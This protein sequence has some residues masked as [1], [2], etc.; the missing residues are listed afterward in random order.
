MTNKVTEL[1]S[2]EQFI[3]DYTPTYQP[4]YPLLMK[5]AVSYS[6]EVGEVKFKRL[7]VVGDIRQKR[8]TPKQNVMHQFGAKMGTKQFAKY[9]FGNQF[10]QSLFQSQDGIED[11]VRQALDEHQKQADELA[12]YGEGTS[13]GTVVNNGLFYSGDANHVTNSSVELDTDADTLID[14][15]TQ[16]MSIKSDADD[17]A[18][19]KLMLFY[20]ANLRSLYD[21]N[22]S[23]DPIPFKRVLSEAC[24]PNYSFAKIPT[25]VQPAS[26]DGVIIVNLDQIKTHYMTL[27]VLKKQG[28]ND[29]KDY[30]WFNFLMGSMMVEVL[31]NGAVIRQPF[32][33]EA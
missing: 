9:F 16:L 11:I 33:L 28:I 21:K 26:G 29:E 18:G 4:I 30:A 1:K 31:A 20:G 14:L 6:E 13:D 32:T 27:P 24:G 3:K 23:S 19:E 25:A 8:I 15:H 22:Y 7:E 2:I 5:N 10:T 12:L 17:I